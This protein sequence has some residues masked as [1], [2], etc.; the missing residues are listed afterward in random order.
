MKGRKNLVIGVS[1]ASGAPLAAALLQTL[2]DCPSWCTHLVITRGGELTI[3]AETGMTAAQVKELAD[4]V[5]DP[6]ELDAPIASGSF[7]TAGM[8]VVPCSM[9]TVA[10]I[11]N[12]YSENLL[13]R[14][15]DVALKERRKLV[16]VA[17]ETPLSA[18]HL[19][20]MLTVTEAGAVVL[21]PVLTY[22]HHPRDIEE[23]TRQVVG[24]ILDQFGIEAPFYSRWGVRTDR[25]GTF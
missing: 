3:E 23:M 22:Y 25:S 17:R 2:R 13:L 19:R 16:L 20:N 10:G 21:P 7:R 9:K 8:V 5:Y 1:G 15:A 4:R 12:G 6:S 24:K 14:A 18:I 11:A